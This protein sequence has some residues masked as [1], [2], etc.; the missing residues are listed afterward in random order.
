MINIIEQTQ[1]PYQRADPSLTSNKMNINKY[2]F[3]IRS[4]LMTS[5]AI[6]NLKHTTMTY[7]LAMFCLEYCINWSPS[8]T[9]R[10]SIRYLS[11]EAVLI[12]S[13][14]F[15]SAND[16]SLTISL[17]A[18]RSRALAVVAQRCLAIATSDAAAGK[19]DPREGANR[20]SKLNTSSRSNR[21]PGGGGG[22]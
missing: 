1:G 14:K 20:S 11:A 15:F 16:M 13:L 9:A 17:S 12:W 10:C 19:R 18:K 21:G 6:G 2:I 4:T 3:S 5:N 8:T 7:Y 22:E